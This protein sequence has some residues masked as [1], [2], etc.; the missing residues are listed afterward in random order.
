LLCAKKNKH[1][2][3][4]SLISHT[5]SYSTKPFRSWHFHHFCALWDWWTVLHLFSL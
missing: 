1:T 3:K 2:L 4:K 5:Y